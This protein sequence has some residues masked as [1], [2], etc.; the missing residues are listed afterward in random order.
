MKHDLSLLERMHHGLC[1]AIETGGIICYGAIRTKGYC[2]K[3]YQR[4]LKHGSINLI[5]PE[6]KKCKFLDCER[7]Y[8]SKSYCKK[9]YSFYIEKPKKPNAKCKL[10][11]CT[12]Y[13][14]STTSV[15]PMHRARFKKFKTY[16]GSG[17]APGEVT[18]FKI[19][20]TLNKKDLRCCIVADCVVDSNSSEITKGLCRKHYHRWRAHKDY[21]CVKK[22]GRSKN[23]NHSK[24]MGRE[25]QEKES[26]R[27]SPCI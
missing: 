21:N 2:R 13:E 6:K 8:W 3:H 9:H 15:C 10:T 20:H 17:L 23:V 4:L 27:D 22:R 14:E 16:E 1:T 11:Q 5:V 26:H 25:S 12:K 7:P 18:R 19:G 24:Q